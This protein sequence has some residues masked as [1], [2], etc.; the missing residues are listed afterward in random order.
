M[1][2]NKYIRIDISLEIFN[3]NKYNLIEFPKYQQVFVVYKF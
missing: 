2:A 3:N 1:I